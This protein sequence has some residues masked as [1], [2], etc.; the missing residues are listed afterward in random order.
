MM[1]YK[2]KTF[3]NYWKNCKDGKDCERALTNKIMEDAEK[4]WGKEPNN[5]PPINI[6]GDYPECFK[7]KSNG[8]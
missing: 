4:W 6:F 7:G 3:C 1:C 2:D 8:K 5:P